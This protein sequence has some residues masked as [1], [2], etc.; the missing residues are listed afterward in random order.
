MQDKLDQLKSHLARVRDLELVN[1]VL[2][3]DME[4]LM[5]EGAAK[6]RADQTATMEALAHQYFVDEEIGSL[7]DELRDFES[8]LPFDSN[9]ASIIRVNRRDYEQQVRI[10]THLVE[11]LAR[12]RSLSYH[13]WMKARQQKDFSIFEADLARMIDLQKQ[14][15]AAL[16]DGGNPYD[17]LLDIFEPGMTYE[18]IDTVFSGLKPNLIKLVEAITANKDRVDDSILRFPL[19]LDKQEAFAREVTAKFGFDYTKGRL[20]FFNGHPFET[21][22]YQGD[23]RITT[24]IE[25]DYPAGALMS[26]IHEAGHGMYEQGVSLDLY[27]TRLDNGASSSIH[28]SQSRFFENVIGRSRPFLKY[29]YPKFQQ[30][31]TPN[32]GNVDLDTFYRAINK[33][34]PSLIRVDADEVTYG[35]HVILRFELENDLINGRVKVS[36]LPKEWNSRMKQYLGVTPP[37]DSKGVLQDVHWSAGLFGYFPDYL[38]GTIFSV[39]L[40]EQMKKDIPDVEAQIE[41]GEFDQVLGWQ[42]KNVHVHGKKFTLPELSERVTGGPLR[43]EPYMNYLQAKY[44]EIYR[45]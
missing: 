23:V 20:D 42:R 32:L 44:S 37:D 22:F 14:V 39:Q 6:S 13:S 26:S 41:R 1:S 21:H 19:S 8:S 5:P 9:E 24:R 7:L 36:D 31:T 18:K 43:W 3:W 29:W 15:A 2:E 11:E 4:V 25:E 27:R 16:S 12:H 10:P 40:W 28:E 17:A 33:S 35:L 34:E 38:L 30:I 45:L